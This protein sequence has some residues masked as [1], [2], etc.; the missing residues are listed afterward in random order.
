MCFTLT[1]NRSAVPKMELISFSSAASKHLPY[2]TLYL[3]HSASTLEQGQDFTACLP[4]A[5]PT[6]TICLAGCWVSRMGSYPSRNW[7]TL[8]G[9][10]LWV[11]RQVSHNHWSLSHPGIRPFLSGE[12]VLA[13]LGVIQPFGRRQLPSSSCVEK[14]EPPQQFSKLESRWYV[15]KPVLC[16]AVQM[17]ILEK[18]FSRVEIILVAWGLGHLH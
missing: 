1:R 7:L 4:T 14:T 2:A 11:R 13:A 15:P 9:Y 6:A 12:P 8:R 17:S 16:L 5:L 18:M 3:N 10:I